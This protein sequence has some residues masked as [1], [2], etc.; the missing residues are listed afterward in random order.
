VSDDSVAA[1]AERPGGSREAELGFYFPTPVDGEAPRLA[2]QAIAEAV[3]RLLDDVVMLDAADAEPGAL[4]E[5]LARV[6]AVRDRLSSLPSLRDQ[7]RDAWPAEEASQ[8]AKGPVSG[9]C[10]PLAPPVH[11]AQ[12]EAGVTGWAVYGPA[13]EGG[14]G[15]VHAGL[16]AAAFADLLGS[17]QFA[18]PAAG[19]TGTLTVRYRSITPLNQRI[20][21]RGRIDR[22]EGR[23][24]FS[25]AESFHGDTL[26]AEAE[27]IFVAART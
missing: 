5:A 11:L 17:A 25:S 4:E 3:R 16:Q 23:K 6:E 13:H 15:Y 18:G 27:A 24:T 26:C 8:R 12:S 2:K 22:V 14:T 1:G 9:L 21:F 19:R 10:N 20:D 7:P